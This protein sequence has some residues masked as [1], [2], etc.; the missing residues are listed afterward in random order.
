[1]SYLSIDSGGLGEFGCGAGCSCK[2]CRSNLAEV[3]EEEEIPE[4]RPRKAAP[5]IGAWFGEVSPAPR[6]SLL[7]GQ[8]RMP[9][10]EALT[11][12]AP[13]GWWTGQSGLGEFRKWV[14]RRGRSP[15]V[16]AT[17]SPITRFGEPPGPVFNVVCPACPLGAVAQCR[18]AV[19]AAIIEA[20]RLANNAADKIEAAI[21]VPPDKRDEESRQT[22]R[23]FVG[24]FGHDPSRPV[25]W[26]GNQ[27]SGVSVA[28]RFR[29][30]ARELNGGRRL[31]FHCRPTQPHCANNDLTCCCPADNAWFSLDVPNTVNLCAPFWNPP[32]GLHGLPARNYRAAIII[33]EMLHMLFKDL[34][35]VGRGRPRAACY[36]A[37]ALRLAGFG[38]DPFDVCNCRGTPCPPDPFPPCP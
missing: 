9:A 13:V 38:A 15:A 30:V 33:H 26:A 7:L 28:S 6:G 25:P 22:A 14:H 21:N 2:Q 27:A 29:S 1:M 24:F 31:V 16:E 17:L 34:R 8:S 23:F 10:L 4:P 35:D 5:K 20:V 11:G 32:A 3:Y 19:R 37:F 12:H 18:A 36:E